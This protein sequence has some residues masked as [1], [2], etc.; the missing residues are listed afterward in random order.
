MREQTA[1]LNDLHAAVLVISFESPAAL[2]RFHWFRDLPFLVV[3]DQSRRLYN[4]FGLRSR[5]LR[6]LFDR[7]TMKT[8][9]HELLRGH[10]PLWPR[11]DLRQLGGDVVL[12]RAGNVVFV[13][14]SATP[15]DRPS[16]ETLLRVLAAD[17]Q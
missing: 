7:E 4:S 6:R 10:L 5:P 2:R 8:Y 13:H 9:A 16:V 11:A 15:A 14:R 3:S 1:R 12:N 17:G